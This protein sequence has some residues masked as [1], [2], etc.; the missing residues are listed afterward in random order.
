MTVLCAISLIAGYALRLYQPYLIGRALA[1]W[2]KVVA[3][4]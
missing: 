4:L 2:A 1:L 3:R